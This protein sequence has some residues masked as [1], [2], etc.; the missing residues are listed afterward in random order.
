[1]RSVTC[2]LI[3]TSLDVARYCSATMQFL[4]IYGFAVGSPQAVLRRDPARIFELVTSQQ[5]DLRKHRTQGCP[6]RSS[7]GAGPSLPDELAS[8][9]HFAGDLELSVIPGSP[10]TPA[11]RERHD[12]TI[13]TA[14][15]TGQ[16][17]SSGWLTELRPGSGLVVH[18]VQLRLNPAFSVPFL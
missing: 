11:Y 7:P 16:Q 18:L 14:E 12:R 1:M 3:L 4:V 6:S 2:S 15:A 5:G 9:R 10:A 13:A 8:G 17:R